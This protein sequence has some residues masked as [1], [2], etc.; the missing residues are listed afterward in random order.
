MRAELGNISRRSGLGLTRTRIGRPIVRPRPDL[1]GCDPKAGETP[2]PL[3]RVLSSP[4]FTLVELLVAIAIVAILIALLITNLERARSAAGAASCLNNLRSIGQ[5]IALYA[6]D[7]AGKIPYGPK[8]RPS[9]IADFYVVDGLVTSQVSIRSGG[10]PV[11]LGLLLHSYLF[12]LPQVVFCPQADQHQDAEAELAKVGTTQAVSSYF[13]RHGSN[14][15]ES[16]SK[17]VETWDDHIQLDN[18]GLNRRGLPITALVMDQQFVVNP[19]LPAFNIFSRTNHQRQFSNTL[20]ID[21]HAQALPNSDGRYTASIGNALHLGPT[22][23]LEVL[24][25]ADQKN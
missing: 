10:K 16:A 21:G 15:L 6:Q 22:R 8:A 13:Y 2:A 11:G 7:S 19:P 20:Y 1:P 14:T 17:P 24:E 4:A 18:L 25:T 12:D 3:L 23:M 9:S 5:A